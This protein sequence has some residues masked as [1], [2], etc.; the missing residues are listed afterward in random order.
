MK[1]QILLG[2]ELGEKYGSEWKIKANS[3]MDIAD[4]IE[5]N[6]PGFREDIGE[7]LSNGGLI[8]MENGEK[9]LDEEDLLLPIVDDTIII[10]PVPAGAQSGGAKMLLGAALVASVFFVPLSG[11]ASLATMA[12][13]ATQAA[14][15][16]AT[17]TT[18]QM[19]TLAAFNGAIGIGLNLALVGMQQM[20]APDPS[21]DD[22]EQNYLFDG[23][24]QT[25]LS[26]TPVPYL[27]GRKI[28]P[29]TT[30]SSTVIVGNIPRATNYY[31]DWDFG[32][33]NP[34]FE[35]P[36]GGYKNI[37]QMYGNLL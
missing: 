18:T 22:N 27:Y 11:G 32:N 7:F 5:A 6:Y 8:S 30:I 33:I 4:C 34:N 36:K 10:T 31:Y 14:A 28:I 25:A 19:A 12:G 1:R 2:G 15:T 24:E 17:L 20:L 23:T 35:A 16:G 3:Y 13:S 21:V 29:G 37:S 26:S 9:F